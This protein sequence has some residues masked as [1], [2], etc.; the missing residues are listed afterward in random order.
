MLILS[1][2]V[3]N[4]CSNF[5]ELTLRSEPDIKVKGIN[6]GLIELDLIAIIENPNSQSF[7]VKNADFDIYLNDSKIGHSSMKKAI[8]I[9]G[10]STKE[11]TF[12]V[13]VKLGDENLSLGLLL[14]GLFSNSFDLKVKGKVKAGSFLVN[15]SFPVEWEDQVKL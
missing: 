5:E 15:Q 13:K 14:G 2:L 3:L 11:Y 7:K 9:E 1:L 12:P 4:S 8:K 6:D 10:N